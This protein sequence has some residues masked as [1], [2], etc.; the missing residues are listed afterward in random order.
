MKY[1]QPRGILEEYTHTVS[2]QIIQKCSMVCKYSISAGRIGPEHS[3]EAKMLMYSYQ[4]WT[5]NITNGSVIISYSKMT[6]YIHEIP[7]P[8]PD[9]LRQKVI[10]HIQPKME[11]NS[12]DISNHQTISTAI[13][14][15]E[16]QPLASLISI[17]SH[18]HYQSLLHSEQPKPIPPHS[19]RTLPS[20]LKTLPHRLPN[21]LR[22]LHLHPPRTTLPLRRQ[23]V[24]RK[25]RHRTGL[26]N[27]RS[28]ERHGRRAQRGRP[29]A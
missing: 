9:P 13:H 17:T 27:S 12:Q 5:I 23:P 24:L 2:F 3:L 6:G 16:L 1:A 25:P 26:I 19:N 21:S 10:R 18:K 14:P 20:P 15:S 11:P 22:I 28:T 7:T 29:R 8:E 4:R